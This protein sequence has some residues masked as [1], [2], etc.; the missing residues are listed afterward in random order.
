MLDS[1]T[2]LLVVSITGVLFLT[3]LTYIIIFFTFRKKDVSKSPLPSV[4][5][6]VVGKNEAENW[7]RILP[8]LL[9]QDHPN[10]EIVAVNDQSIDDS[11]D[12]IE[13]I[14]KTDTRIRLV[15]VEP[16]EAFIKGKKYALTLGIKAAKY[17]HL[18]F[19]DADCEPDSKNWLSSMAAGFQNGHIVLGYGDYFKRS[20]FLNSLIRWETLHTAVMSFSAAAV[21]KA[22]MGIG[23][24]LAYTKS[25]FFACKGFYD[26]MHLPM[27]DDDLFVNRAAPRTSV[28][29]VT[30]TKTNSFPKERWSD[31][32]RQKRRHMFSS[33]HYRFRTKAYL[34]V[35]GISKAFFYIGFL[36]SLLGLYASFALV[37]WMLYVILM[38]WSAYHVGRHWKVGNQAIYSIVMDPFYV[39]LQGLLMIINFFKAPINRWK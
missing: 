13:S 17:E 1:Q 6:V 19:T 33:G 5:L 38:T 3:Q 36:A 15:N 23:R 2:A 27:G 31:W 32:W 10:F 28:S 9:N 35:Y 14:M 29:W 30:G 12:I 4:S 11:I 39:V 26:H 18:V 8:A 16:N 24:N 37:L 7:K 34:S 21:G 25:L 22:Y 20:G